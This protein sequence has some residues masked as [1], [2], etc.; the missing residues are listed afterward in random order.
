MSER[1]ERDVCVLHAT[2]TTTHY[3]DSLTEDLLLADLLGDADED[4]DAAQR[5]EQSNGHDNEELGVVCLHLGK[6]VS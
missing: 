1:V 3:Y 2:L 6:L 4:G 5:R